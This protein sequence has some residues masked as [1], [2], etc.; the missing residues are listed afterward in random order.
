MQ[1]R[2]HVPDHHVTDETGEHEHGEVSHLAAVQSVVFDRDGQQ[3]L[4][5]SG[6]TTLK[7]W[8]AATGA[9]LR[10]RRGHDDWVRSIAIRPDGRRFASVGRDSTLR[11]WDI[12]TMTQ[13]VELH[14]HMDDISCVVYS[15]DGNTIATG[16]AGDDHVFSGNDDGA[17][18]YLKGGPGADERGDPPRSAR[19]PRP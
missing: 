12:G 17:W 13:D 18:D 14:G 11:I 8:D 2:G 16:G 3:I 10:T 19:W 9:L 4:S 7:L 6:D 1:R 5:A 15:P